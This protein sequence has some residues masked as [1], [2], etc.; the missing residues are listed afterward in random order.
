[1][2]ACPNLID[3]ALWTDLD[4]SYFME[5]FTDMK[6]ERLSANVST[7][8]I[9]V[10]KGPQF[11]NITHL[12]VTKFGV[13]SS[14]W[15]GLAFLPRLTDVAVNEVLDNSV[16]RWLLEECTRLQVLAVLIRDSQTRAWKTRDIVEVDP[17]F[18]MMKM[19]RY[20]INDWIASS[21]GERNMWEWAEEI[22]LAKRCEWL[23]SNLRAAGF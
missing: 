1:M 19:P 10:F 9:S 21:S 6:L 4:I 5:H 11:S 3:L 13:A 12:D 14:N 7:L 8:A 18:V 15:R 23:V 22:S 16:F 2:A 17:R 20:I